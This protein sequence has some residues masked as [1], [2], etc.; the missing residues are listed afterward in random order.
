MRQRTLPACDDAVAARTTNVKAQV[1]EANVPVMAAGETNALVLPKPG[2]FAVGLLVA[3][4]LKNAVLTFESASNLTALPAASFPTVQP[5]VSEAAVWSDSDR[6]LSGMVTP[7]RL[8]VTL[9][10][11]VVN[12][13]LLEPVRA[14]GLVCDLAGMSRPDVAASQVVRVSAVGADV[15]AREQ[16]QQ[17]AGA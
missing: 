12:A 17:R 9:Y 1:P 15:A 13:H 7:S 10:V 5:P 6:T 3:G 4:V 11:L 2:V 8:V 16:R 14:A